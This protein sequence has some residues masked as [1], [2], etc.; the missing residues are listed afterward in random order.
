[1]IRGIEKNLTH[2]SQY[3]ERLSSGEPGDGAYFNDYCN[4]REIEEFRDYVYN[5]PAASIAGQLMKSSQSTFYHE[6]VLVK[7]AGSSKKTPWHVDQSYYPVEGF[8]V[9]S[10]W[11]PVDRIG[12]ES[13]IQFVSGSHL[14]PQR[15]IP[16]KFATTLNYQLV[17][18][19]EK[20]RYVN[21]PDDKDIE[22]NYDI[23]KWEVVPGDCIAFHMKTLHGAPGNS[24]KT[25][26]RRILSTR[27]F[28]TVPIQHISNIK[29]HFSIFGFP[30]L[31]HLPDAILNSR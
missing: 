29:L 11:M 14:W 22:H 13:T 8:Q 4:W 3:G 28:G 12:V 2:P 6:H 31:F 17:G 21:V 9:C 7:E 30:Y 18:S 5:S 24:S 20:G 25:S 23:L 27:W 19:L 16:R 26:S 1:V 10:I 15:F